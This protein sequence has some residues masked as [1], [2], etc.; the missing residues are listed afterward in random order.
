[1]KDAILPSGKLVVGEAYWLTD[2]VPDAYRAQEKDVKTEVDLLQIAR[3]EGFDLEYVVRAS[4]DDWDRYESDNWSG[5]L[6]WIEE[7]PDHAER[8]QV[9]DHLHQ[10]Q[11]E[12]TRY[13]RQYFGWAIYVLNPVR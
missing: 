13:A 5:L 4:H 8:Q 9:I 10:S 6:R 11:D 1:M 12:Y 2:N 7:N 3:Q